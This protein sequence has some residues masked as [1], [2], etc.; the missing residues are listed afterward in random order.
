[1][2]EG[3][4]DP[5]EID[6]V[7]D[8]AGWIMNTDLLLDRT[9]RVHLLYFKR[10]IQ[11]AF[12]RDR[13]FPGRPMT[14]EIVHVVIDRG[15]VV[16][17]QIVHTQ[18]AEPLSADSSATRPALCA[19]LHQ[20][21]DGRLVAVY[22]VS[23]PTAKDGNGSL[24]LLVRRLDTAGAA[25]YEPSRVPLARPVFSEWA[26]FTNTPRGGSAPDGQLDLLGGHVA[27]NKMTLCHVSLRIE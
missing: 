19:R 6:S 21:A 25:V 26:F 3:F 16:A 1:M 5:V 7:E 11:Y 13:F 15:R 27:G 12:L 10:T 9:G 17:R 24:D 20:L 2:T 4:R 22:T 14:D 23:E 18:S 8:T